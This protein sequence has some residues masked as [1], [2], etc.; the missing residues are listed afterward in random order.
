MDNGKG[1][2]NYGECRGYIGIMGI[3]GL[4]GIIENEK[5]TA[6]TG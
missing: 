5:E 6:M 1:N 4:Y 3:L 2:G